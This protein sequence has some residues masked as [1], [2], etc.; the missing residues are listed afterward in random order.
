[1]LEVER[2]IPLGERV[3]DV[4][5][6][7]ITDG[8]LA[9][10]HPVPESVLAKQL[11]VSRSPVKAALTRLQGDGLVVSEAWKVPRVAPLD[12]K[13]INNAYQVRKALDGQ[14]ALQAVGNIPATEI[15]EFAA[16]LE[17]ARVALLDEELSLVREAFF[18]FQQMLVDHCDNDLLRNMQGILVDHLTRIR[19]AIHTTNDAEWLRMEYWMLNDQ[20]EALRAR[21]AARVV[22]TLNNQHDQFVRWLFKTWR[23]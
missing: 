23:V 13:Y 1:M 10:D 4:I 2:N 9:P 22:A 20:L 14:C 19:N 6:K 16:K 11:G 7:M 8:D 21:D 15:E 18:M 12:T 17:M 3:Y 5:K